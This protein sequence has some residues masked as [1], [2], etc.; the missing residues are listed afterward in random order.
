MLIFFILLQDDEL[1][2]NF[3]QNQF[4]LSVM[5]NKVSFIIA[6]LLL[7]VIVAYSQQTIVLKPGPSEGK[8]ARVWSIYPNMISGDYPYMKANAWTWG[9]QFGI[10]RSFIEFDLDSVPPNVEITS[11]YLSFFYHFL[12]GNIEQTHSGDNYSLIQRIVAP[13]NE[14]TTSWD[15]QPMATSANE[16]IVHPSTEPQED[17]LDIDVTDLVIDMLNDPEN[18][19]GFLFRLLNEEEYRRLAFA[20]SDH[21]DPEKWPMLVITYDCDTPVVDF[22]FVVETEFVQF[23][24]LSLNATS[25]YWDF[26]DGYFSVLQNPIHTYY[27]SGPYSVCL[28]VENDCGTD[29]MCDTVRPVIVSVNSNYSVNDIA[30]FPNPTN[31]YVR[32]A[33]GNLKV[34]YIDMFVL[35]TQGDILKESRDYFEEENAVT[36]D[37]SDYKPGIYYLKLISGD[38][39]TV[40]K[41]IVR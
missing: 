27:S 6:F 18:S 23:N 3:M 30:I 7:S 35:N 8:D 31:D 37:F 25:W 20:S 24:D 34:G 14:S 28:T 26:G 10:E 22:D 9:G 40:K 11:A 38:F 29:M 36:I 16:V 33:F 4:K 32:V 21:P 15:N 39:N 5:K 2:C 41:I 19:H 17:F 13:W 1:I 12:G